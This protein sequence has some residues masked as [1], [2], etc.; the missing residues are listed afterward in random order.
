MA[1]RSNKPTL[2]FYAVRY[3]PNGHSR[4]VAISLPY[5]ASIAGEAH[6]TA[7]P[8]PPRSERAPAMT[9][10]A[11]RRALGRDP[12]APMSPRDGAGYE[13]AMRRIEREGA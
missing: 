11:I 3:G 5:V 7:P 4:P 10:R 12:E 9:D 2:T 6:Y 1:M 8:P 13:A